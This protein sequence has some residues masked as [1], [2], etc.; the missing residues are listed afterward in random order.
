M[1]SAKINDPHQHSSGWVA[2]AWIS[3]ALSLA[4]TTIGLVYIPIDGWSK[5]YLA[6][7]T[8]FTISSTIN[9]SK[10]SRDI[11]EARKFAARIDEARVERL[12]AEHH[13]LK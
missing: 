5:G 1:S 13:P 9:I 10:T 4:A 3:F 2:Q 8:I 7:S 12:L 11:H 6:I